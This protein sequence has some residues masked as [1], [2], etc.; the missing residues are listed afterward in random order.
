MKPHPKGKRSHA[1]TILRL[2]DPEVTKA[3]VINSLS[4]PDAQRGYRHAIEEFVEW[5]CSGPRLS[6]SRTVVVD[7]ECTSNRGPLH[8]EQSTSALVRCAA[9]HTKQPSA[10]YS[11]RIW[12]QE[13]GASNVSGSWVS[14]WATG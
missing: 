10:A 4:C 14:G 3:A 5:Y 2:P 7:I 6:F 11:A 13:Y 12:L 8:Q 9:L 1:K